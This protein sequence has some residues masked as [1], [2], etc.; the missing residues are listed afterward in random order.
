MTRR[1][2]GYY[3]HHHGA[4]HLARAN[5]I[6]AASDWPVVLLGTGIGDRGIDLSDDRLIPGGFDGLD[7]AGDRPEAL[8]Y[9]PLDHE[10]IRSRIAKVSEWIA[11]ARPALM[12][13]DVSVEIAMLARLAS[14]PVVYVRLNGDR[15]DPPHA[16][17]FASAHALLAP[18]HETFER[19]ETPDWVRA[20]T[21]YLPGITPVPFKAGVEADRILIV[22]GRGGVPGNSAWIADAAR[23]CPHKSW[24][25]IGPVTPPARCPSNL[26]FAGWVD[27]PA[28]EIARAACVI[29]AAGDGLVGA[30][31]AADR[32]FICL[33]EDR[34]F[35]EQ[36]ATAQAL[37]RLGAAIV[38]KQSP[39]P[40]EWPDLIEREAAIPSDVRRRLHD[41]LGAKAAAVWLAALAGR[42]I[43]E[44]A[45]AA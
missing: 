5:A 27:D 45:D 31:L 36:F 9:A 23:A 21:R 34:P 16:Q 17:A 43:G 38:L 37:E 20:K 7:G 42:Y 6:A 29:G 8:H 33:P 28:S 41:P 14:V 19:S 25:V 44:R 15:S 10:G 18:F 30:V 13:V 1:P 35:G 2:I 39:Q 11:V 32:S 26:I 24:R 3:V 40:V 22:V 12:V 4:G